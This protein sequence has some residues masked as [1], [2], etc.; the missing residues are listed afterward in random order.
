M[1][2][3]DALLERHRVFVTGHEPMELAT[4]PRLRL[5]IVSCM[6]SRLD[7]FAALGL[8]IG[9]AH[10]IRNAGGIATDDVLRSL[11]LSQ[12]AL[13]TREV[14]VIQ[15]TRCGL[16]GLDEAD[17]ADRLRDETGEAP[18]F[19][20]GAFADLPANVRASVESIRHCPFLP[21]RDGVRGFVCDVSTSAL[22]EIADQPDAG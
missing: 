17:F 18:P 10:V 11:V 5:A 13:G 8:Q 4:E 14:M 6:D 12:Q 9:E 16:H 20:M 19:S 1:S 7:I 2:A 22:H 3:I 15:H 21:H